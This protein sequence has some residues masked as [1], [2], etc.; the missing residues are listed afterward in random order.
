[1]SALGVDASSCRLDEVVLFFLAFGSM[2]KPLSVA[3]SSLRYHTTASALVAERSDCSLYPESQA[4]AEVIMLGHDGDQILSII[5]KEITPKGIITIAQ[6]PLA[7]GALEASVRQGIRTV[8]NVTDSEENSD[9]ET[10]SFDHHIG[11]FVELLRRSA[12]AGKDVVW[13]V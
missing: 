2:G 12:E 7:I 1:M 6:I 9:E 4:A 10:V 5:G 13:G 11:P 8:A 3:V